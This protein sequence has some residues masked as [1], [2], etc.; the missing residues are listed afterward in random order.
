M[1]SRCQAS[2][3][4]ALKS[5]AYT[6][7]V[8][9]QPN[10]LVVSKE[11]IGRRI[12][13]LR[14]QREKSQVELAAALEMTQSNLSAIERGARGVTVHQ[15]VRI[16]KALGASTDEILLGANVPAPRKSL[17]H[18]R[19]MQRAQQIDLLSDAER[20]LVLDLLDGLLKRR[21]KQPARPRR[22]SPAAKASQVA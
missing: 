18:R 13:A 2:S 19:F 11:E 3:H 10:Q 4:L 6:R 15:V 20:R 14:Q 21:E 5:A 12:R 16:A 22:S 7:G 17:R 8:G 9:K 1:C